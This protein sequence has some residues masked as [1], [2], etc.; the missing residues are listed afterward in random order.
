MGFYVLLASK[1][2]ATELLLF[3]MV[4][5]VL[6]NCLYDFVSNRTVQTTQT[7]YHDNSVE[8]ELIGTLTPKYVNMFCVTETQI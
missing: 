4:R 6:T 7:C 1:K 5:P 2:I 8:I 3:E